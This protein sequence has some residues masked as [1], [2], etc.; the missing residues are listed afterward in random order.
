MNLI[1]MNTDEPNKRLF[2]C[3]TQARSARD[4]LAETLREGIAELTNE[5]KAQKEVEAI[6]SAQDG[7][8]SQ[9]M[10]WMREF[11][12]HSNLRSDISV[13]AELETTIAWIYAEERRQCAAQSSPAA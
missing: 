10:R 7:W 12:D 4:R 1:T 9:L 13:L 6:C 8:R 3:L 11:E 5:S 2:T